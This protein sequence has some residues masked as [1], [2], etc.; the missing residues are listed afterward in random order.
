MFVPLMYFFIGKGIIESILDTN[1]KFFFHVAI[2]RN[3]ANTSAEL[4]LV[5]VTMLMCAKILQSVGILKSY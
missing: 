1:L 3:E 2:T 4:F 5:F